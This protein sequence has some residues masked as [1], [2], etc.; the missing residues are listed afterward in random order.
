MFGAP[1][2]L[3]LGYSHRTL[4][5]Q[6]NDQDVRENTIS[7]GLGFALSQGRSRVDLGVLRASRGTID[8]VSEHAW[9]FSAGIM[10]RP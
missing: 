1:L 5:F 8:G 10:V 2:A 9:T 4:P 7:A 3:R 6:V